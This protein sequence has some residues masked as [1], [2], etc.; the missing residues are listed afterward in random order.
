MSALSAKGSTA[1]GVIVAVLIIGAVGVIGYYQV[2]VAPNQLSTGTT[3][4]TSGAAQVNCQTTPTKCVNV[5]IVSGAGTPYSGYSQGSTT[6]YGYDPS[7]TTVVIGVNNTVVWTNK[8]VAFHTATSNAGDPA[9][10]ESGCINGQGAP[11]ASAGVD[12]YQFTFTVP[13]TYL[14]HCD[15]HPWML[16]KVIVVQGSGTTTTGVSTATTTGASSTTSSAASGTAVQA[17][18]A[19]GAS[20]PYSGY[21]SGSTQLYGYSPVNITVVIGVNNT[22][23]WTN[24]DGAFHTVTSNPGDPASFNSGCLNGVG[25]PCQGSS[26]GSSFT[27]TFTVPGTYVYHCEYHPWMKGEVIVLPAK[28]A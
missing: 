17:T 15:Y 28:S 9:S 6:L 1:V 16:G 18:I 4:T 14:Y 3:S 23:T 24:V 13:G 22:V 10:F 27:F 26:I 25:A 11:C 8:D 12:S 19:S 2:E 7:T 5:T 21:G 20:V